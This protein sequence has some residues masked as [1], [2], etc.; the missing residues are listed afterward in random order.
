M[1]STLFFEN[2]I[3]DRKSF[4]NASYYAYLSKNAY[5][6]GVLSSILY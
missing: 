2:N 5:T 4:E 1:I 3:T 6:L